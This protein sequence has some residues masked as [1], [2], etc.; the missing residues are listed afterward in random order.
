VIFD[1]DGETI[2]A[3]YIGRRGTTTYA[4]N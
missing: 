4:R 3:I 2:L 1:D